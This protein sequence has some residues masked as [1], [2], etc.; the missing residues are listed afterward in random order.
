[1]SLPIRRELEGIISTQ[2]TTINYLKEKG[3]FYLIQ[4]FP[5]CNSSVALHGNQYRC[6]RLGCRK[7]VSLF[8]NTFFANSRVKSNHILELAYYWL[9][10]CTH[11]AALT[12]TGMSSATITDYYGHFRQLVVSALDNTDDII[13]GDNIIVEI[14]G[15]KFGKRKHHRGHR[16]EDA[17]VAGGIKRT[18]QKRFSLK[19]SRTEMPQ[20]SSTL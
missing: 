4:N 13:G 5:S 15:S 16:I 9:R 1:M 2:E 18:E 17:W 7:S 3:V 10:G 11:T 14:D 19:S 12:M 20:H 6:K 8:R